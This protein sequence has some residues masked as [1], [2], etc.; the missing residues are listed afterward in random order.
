M[1]ALAAL[2]SLGGLI[3]AARGRRAEPGDGREVALTAAIIAGWTLFC[4]LILVD[5]P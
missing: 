1:V 2:L 4:I 5:W 3:A